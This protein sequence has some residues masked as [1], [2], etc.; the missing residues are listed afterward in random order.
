MRMSPQIGLLIGSSGDNPMAGVSQDSTSSKYCPSSNAQWTTTMAAAGITSGNPASLWLCQ[1]AS[2]NL[3]D[4]IGAV[5]LTAANNPTYSNSVTGWTRKAAATN[6]TAPQCHFQTTSVADL[7]TT[8]YALLAYVSLTTPTGTRELM[9]FGN[10][11]DHRYVEVSTTPRYTSRVIL[12]G[13]TAGTS[14][15]GTAV[16]PI[17]LM[18]NRASSKFKTYTDQEIIEQA[19]AAPTAGGALLCLGDA[20]NASAPAAYFLYAAGFSGTAAEFS[21]AQ[22]RSLFRSLGWSIPW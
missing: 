15:P 11:F 9:G 20:V 5:T 7:S 3:A 14:D 21:D 17:L 2:G 13:G 4:S 8:S 1:E 10:S 22:V 18:V 19:W 16:R 12:G 6:E